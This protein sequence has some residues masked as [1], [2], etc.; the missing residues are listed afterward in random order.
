MQEEAGALAHNHKIVQC[1]KDGHEGYVKRMAVMS[2]SIKNH[3]LNGN[4]MSGSSLQ[5]VYC[6]AI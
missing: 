2:F 3:K 6:I 5:R 1:I 4:A